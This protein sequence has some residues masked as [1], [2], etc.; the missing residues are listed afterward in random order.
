MTLAL[1]LSEMRALLSRGETRSDL[2]F[3][4]EC[5]ETRWWR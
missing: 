3:N 5:I 1:T 4:S 2:Q